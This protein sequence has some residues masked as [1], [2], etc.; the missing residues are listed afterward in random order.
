MFDSIITDSRLA[1]FS[2]AQNF[3]FDGTSYTIAAGTYSEEYMAHDAVMALRVEV[4]EGATTVAYWTV[5]GQDLSGICTR[6]LASAHLSDWL[7]SRL[8]F[9]LSLAGRKIAQA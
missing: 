1:R 2:T 7:V 3:E 9:T 5:D 4:T 8:A 6:D